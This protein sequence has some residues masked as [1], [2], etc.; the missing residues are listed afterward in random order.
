MALL[1][2]E[3]FPLNPD[4]DSV[5]VWYLSVAPSRLLRFFLPFNSVPRRI[6]QACIDGAVERSLDLG[7]GGRLWLHAAPAGGTK[8]MD[9]YIA[10]CGMKTVPGSVDRLP[11][12]A[13]LATRQNDGRYL[14]FDEAAAS[15]FHARF[16]RYR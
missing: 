1:E 10:T 11:G 5:Y 13:G 7:H 12:I 15:T 9:W 3:R 8:L 14:Y 16:S 4:S 6:G 2:R